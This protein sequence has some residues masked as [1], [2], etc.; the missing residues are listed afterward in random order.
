MTTLLARL[1]SKKP[2]FKQTYETVSVSV[3]GRSRPIKDNITMPRSSPGQLCFASIQL[4][5]VER[6]PVA[7]LWEATIKM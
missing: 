6:H 7:D 2:Y 3:S 4:E 1:S 5:S